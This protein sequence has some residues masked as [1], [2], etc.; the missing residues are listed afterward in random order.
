MSEDVKVIK[1]RMKAMHDLIEE[2]GWGKFMMN[3]GSIM[4]AQSDK[5]ST[6]PQ[7]SALFGCANTIH[8]LRDFWFECGKL[9]FPPELRKEFD[10]D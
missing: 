6:G 2:M 7:S 3:V 1:R 10:C 9:E 4:A 5:A 8:A